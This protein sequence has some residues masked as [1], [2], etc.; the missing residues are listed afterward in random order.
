M[1]KTVIKCLQGS[2]VTQTAGLL[3]I[4]FLQISYSIDMPKLRKLV[5]SGKSYCNNKSDAV[6]WLKNKYYNI[7]TKYA[8]WLIKNRNISLRDVGK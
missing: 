2:V 8:H 7:L 1:G 3:Y 5:G 6:L 4:F